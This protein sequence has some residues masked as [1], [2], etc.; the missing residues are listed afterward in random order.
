VLLLECKQV[1]CTDPFVSDP[2]LVPLAEV[3]EKA[4]LLIVGTPHDCYRSLTFRQRVID[5]TGII[6]AAPAE[7]RAEAE[8]RQTGGLAASGRTA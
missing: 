5:V 4:D 7:P 8:V 3:L 6:K 1:L 2:S